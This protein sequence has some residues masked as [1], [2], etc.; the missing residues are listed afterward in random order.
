MV[1]KVEPSHDAQWI[2]WVQRIAR[3]DEGGLSALYDASSDL[4]YSIALRIL[5]DPSDA[6]EVALDV[7]TQ[8]WRS[9][10][11]FDRSRGAV[12]SWLMMLS[13][14]RSIDKLRGRASR[15]SREESGGAAI[16]RM[17]D[18]GDSPEAAAEITRRRNVVRG[19]LATLSD[20]QREAIELAYYFG[21]SHSELSEL[22][23]QP[24]GTIKTRIRLGMMKLR[25]ALGV[26]DF[27]EGVGA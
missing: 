20:D 1:S 24:V 12:S 21:Y 4:V 26:V 19:A 9:A 15:G 14:S 17:P 23:G 10:S 2:E 3:G 16:E 13:R 7:Y 18:T 22:L 5:T 11:S 6:E 25:T 27:E 8:V